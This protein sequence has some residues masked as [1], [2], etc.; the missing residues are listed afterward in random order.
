MLVAAHGRS[1]VL[2]VAV[3]QRHAVPRFDPTDHMHRPA[4]RL[5]RRQ[6]GRWQGERQ[7]IVVAPAQRRY[8]SLVFT[9]NRQLGLG[10]RQPL[11]L[12]HQAHR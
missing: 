3:E 8:L 2:A 9:D 6:L 7:H 11:A 12:N 1:D 4:I 5:Q 10:Q